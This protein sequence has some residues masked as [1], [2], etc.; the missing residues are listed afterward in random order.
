MPEPAASR[1]PWSTRFEQPADALSESFN[2]SIG[3]DQRLAAY[4]IA[5]SIAHVRMLA[6]QGI[7]QPEEAEQLVAGLS[8]ILEE[9]EAGQ[10]AFRTDREDVHMNVEAALAE[11]IGPVAGK[12]HTGRSRNDQVALDVRLFTR[13]AID[14][15]RLDVLSFIGAL[16]Q[17]AGAH[18]DTILP[19]YT[20]VQRAQPVLLAHHFLAYVE[21]ARR[22]ID[23]L[24][25]A[26]RRTNVLP[27]GAG[28]LAGSTFPL[29]RDDVGQ[30]LHF[31]GITRNSLDAV[32]DRDFVLD[33]LNSCSLIMVH[34]S[35]LA[36]EL[37]WWSSQ[38]FGFVTLSDAYATGSSMMP[39]KKN[40]DSAE[41]V[42]GKAGRVFGH[43]LGM[44]TTLKGLPLSYNK[45]MQEDKEPLF[46][47]YDTVH[48]CLRIMA[49]VVGTLRVHTGAMRTATARGHLTATDLADW[50]VTGGTPFREAHG[51]VATLVRQCERAGR[52]LESLSVAELRAVSPLFNQNAL[53]ALDVEKS[54][55]RRDVPGGTAKGRVE[56]ALHEATVWLS[57]QQTAVT[58]R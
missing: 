39:Q 6:H 12:L 29:D 41:L 5:G 58:E 49:G 13:D 33:F 14:T 54:I 10:F 55:A 8:A 38:E 36:E 22:D 52:P 46:D 53:S 28:A 35:R 19:G 20:H 30:Q 34:L 27:L 40:P 7:I 32:A 56:A 51:I 45:D 11:R 50:L 4:D 18:L 9:I 47:A 26:R 44:L 42:R 25:D 1:Q 17:Q 31:D 15:L 21:M 57:Q 48:N 2:A 43:V 16:L 3:F 24:D 23:R 37:V